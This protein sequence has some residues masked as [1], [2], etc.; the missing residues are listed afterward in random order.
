MVPGAAARSGGVLTPGLPTVRTLAGH[1]LA[2]MC[3]ACQRAVE[4][5]QPALIAAGRGDVPVVELR[6]RCG[7]CGSC[8]CSVVVSASRI[9]RRD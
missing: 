8:N 3:N 4:A 9:G 6:F 2:V 7:A 1:D 5:D